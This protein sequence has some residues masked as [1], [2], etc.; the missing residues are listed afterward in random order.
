MRLGFPSAH[1]ESHFTDERLS[2]HHIDAVDPRQIH[3][4]DAL[5][6]IG[7]MEVRIIFVSLTLLFRMQFLLRWWRDSIGKSSQV[8]L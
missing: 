2:D 5:Q 8:F 3:S 6:F 1:V 4:R 7:E